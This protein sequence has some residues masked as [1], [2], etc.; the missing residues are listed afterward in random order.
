MVRIMVISCILFVSRSTHSGNPLGLLFV[1]CHARHSLDHSPPCAT[2]VFF[3]PS[4]TPSPTH[5]FPKIDPSRSG[6]LP[7]L[8]S[9][10]EPDDMS[11]D[12][13]ISSPRA[14]MTSAWYSSPNA[15]S[16]PSWVPDQND[17]FS[18]GSW[19]PNPALIPTAPSSP[20][21]LSRADASSG[22]NL[23]PASMPSA[24]ASPAR[25]VPTSSSALTERPADHSRP[26]S[27]HEPPSVQPPVGGL[28]DPPPF[29]VI[30]RF[31]EPQ[32]PST[33]IHPSPHMARSAA[34]GPNREVVSDDDWSIYLLGRDRAPSSARRP[35][36]SHANNISRDVFHPWVPRE[37][38]ERPPGALTS[39]ER[40]LDRPVAMTRPQPS[41]GS[42]PHLHVG[43]GA[44]ARTVEHPTLHRIP[45]RSLTALTPPIR[46]PASLDASSW[47]Q[48]GGTLSRLSGAVPPPRTTTELQEQPRMSRRSATPISST[49]PSRRLTVPAQ[50]P[51]P[52]AASAPLDSTGG[53]R[54]LSG[55]PPTPDTHDHP[56]D[57][58][59]ANVFRFSRF[60]DEN[61]LVD[62]ITI[63]PE[64]RRAGPSSTDVVGAESTANDEEKQD[65]DKPEGE[66]RAGDL[67]GRSAPEVRH[68]P[69]GDTAS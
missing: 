65:E 48:Y 38:R 50:D 3:P 62:A 35:R 47:R 30:S 23:D 36:E 45:R 52:T 59:E 18:W 57:E 12:S 44:P 17:A 63:D 25:L 4:V 39:G 11:V 61:A 69:G 51:T 32:E 42:T 41:E 55:S 19:N 20:T 53:H 43:S 37:Q 8:V 5:S 34:S 58:S 68:T 28:E 49:R 40:V 60:L 46:R 7:P 64:L 54:H 24:P 1:P 67:S 29:H 21:E 66:G 10:S 27:W 6:N 33:F 15:Q 9:L 16:Q 26:N 31:S 13:P 2:Y 14:P 22:W 56:G